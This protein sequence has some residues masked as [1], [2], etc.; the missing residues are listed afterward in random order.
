M[1]VLHLDETHELYYF[2]SDFL[3]NTMSAISTA[4]LNLAGSKIFLFPIF[5]STGI[6]STFTLSYTHYKVLEKLLAPYLGLV[7]LVVDLY[8]YHFY[9]PN[10]HLEFF[11]LL[12]QKNIKNLIKKSWGFDGV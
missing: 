5:S 3:R 8:I 4:I 11:L 6:P 12:P 10:Q 1:F 7:V 9:R 2:N